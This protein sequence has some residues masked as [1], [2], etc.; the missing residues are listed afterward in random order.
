MTQPRGGRPKTPQ[1]PDSEA[2]SSTSPW[3]ETPYTI[4]PNCFLLRLAASDLT[5]REIKTLLVIITETVGQPGRQRGA[6]G[7]EQDSVSADEI[8]AAMNVHRSTAFK[9]EAGLIA[10]GWV[11]KIATGAGRAANVLAPRLTPR[12]LPPLAQPSEEVPDT[13]ESLASGRAQMAAFV[14]RHKEERRRQAM[15]HALGRG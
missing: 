13:E 9:A 6:Y 3:R 10:K 4:L 8:A 5:M 12:T 1:T 14:A 15:G 11:D 2:A 7:R